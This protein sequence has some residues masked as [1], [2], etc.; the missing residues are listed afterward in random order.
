MLKI[1]QTL[2]LTN[3]S[4]Q[5]YKIYVKH[6]NESSAMNTDRLLQNGSINDEKEIG[7]SLEIREL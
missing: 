2:R 4:D 1:S 6:L 7:K 5:N 3:T